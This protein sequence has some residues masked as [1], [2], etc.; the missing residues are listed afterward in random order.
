[1]HVNARKKFVAMML[2]C[3]MML[4]LV[5]VAY[6]DESQTSTSPQSES[7][8][9]LPDPPAGS[10][11][12]STDAAEEGTEG[13]EA[14]LNEGGG[15][16]DQEGLP[17]AISEPSASAGLASINNG[18]ALLRNDTVAIGTFNTFAEAVQAIN[19]D[20]GL[21]PQGSYTITV[22]GND[23]DIGKTAQLLVDTNLT[24]RSEGG[25][26][27]T[28]VQPNAGARHLLLMYGKLVVQNIVLD[29]ASTGGGIEM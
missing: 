1:M 29:G 21:S 10:D 22:A 9:S 26:P 4:P 2:S 28:M 11:S 16:L 17:D 13:A 23:D 18:Y 7:S 3:I 27:A 8:T 15:G 25:T 19:D 6:A 20:Y 24:L 5:S 12:A 14:V